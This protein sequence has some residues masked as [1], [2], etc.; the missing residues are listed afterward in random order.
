MTLFELDLF[1]PATR[2]AGSRFDD[3]VANPID[4]PRRLDATVRAVELRLRALPE[5]KDLGHRTIAYR[6]RLEQI[7]HETTQAQAR[8]ADGTYGT[9]LTCSRP[10]SFTRLSERPWAR[11]CVY[12]ELDI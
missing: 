10:I 2:R 1:P 4:T 8:L 12:C 3:T 5:P 7:M 9:C 11:E 6:A